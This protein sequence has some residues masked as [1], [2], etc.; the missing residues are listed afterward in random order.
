MMRKKPRPKLYCYVM[1]GLNLKTLKRTTLKE[2]T[3]NHSCFF[4]APSIKNILEVCSKKEKADTDGCREMTPMKNLE[5]FRA[6]D[7][8]IRT[9]YENE[10][11]KEEPFI[12]EH[13]QIIGGVTMKNKGKWVKIKT[14]YG[15]KDVY[16]YKRIDDYG[17][18]GRITFFISCVGI[19]K[20]YGDHQ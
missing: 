6:Y 11:N 4:M 17:N 9:P 20:E 19:I 15:L 2:A 1:E 14:C 16:F 8:K 5:I 18:Y 3:R 12:I 13:G 7:L 10:E